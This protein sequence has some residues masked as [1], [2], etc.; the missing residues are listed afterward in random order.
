VEWDVRSNFV[1]LMQNRPI[2]TAR[3]PHCLKMAE[4]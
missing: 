1:K 3:Y 4:I 2:L